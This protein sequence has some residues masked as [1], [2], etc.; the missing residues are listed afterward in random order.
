MRGFVFLVHIQLFCSYLLAGG[1]GKVIFS[2]QLWW[3]TLVTISRL[4]ILAGAG[5]W[6]GFLLVILV[7]S[8]NGIP[9]LNI[10][11]CV[12][13]NSLSR[14]LEDSNKHGIIFMPVRF[15]PSVRQRLGRNMERVDMSF[16]DRIR[17]EH[18]DANS[19]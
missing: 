6:A 4:Q 18:N 11:L 14:N 5:V 10:R 12:H 16:M 2:W 13:S 17:N 15:E 3:K 7:C 8:L 9:C 1:V 19:L